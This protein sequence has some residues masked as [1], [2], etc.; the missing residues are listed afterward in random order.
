MI[1]QNSSLPSSLGGA[2]G[3]GQRGKG[4]GER[5][6]GKGQRGKVL[7][8]HLYPFPCPQTS[9]SIFGLVDQ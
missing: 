2:K 1:S 3:K 4:K 5:A 9:P 6:K 8:L 7:N